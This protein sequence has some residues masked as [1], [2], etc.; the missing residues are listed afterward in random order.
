MLGK[1]L[2]K[3]QADIPE[4]DNADGFIETFL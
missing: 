3:R 1:F 4:A 2:Y